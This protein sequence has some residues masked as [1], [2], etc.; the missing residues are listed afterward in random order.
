MIKIGLTGGIGSGKTSVCTVWQK[1]GAYIIN[2]DDLAKEIMVSDSV[3][4]Q[5][6][7]NTFG[8]KTYQPD[9]S[10]NREYL[11]KQAFEKGR[12]NELNGIVHPRIPQKMES[13]VE[14]AEEKGYP[15]LVYEAILLLNGLKNY[16]LD[17]VVIVL[18]DREK[19]LRWTQKRDGV[20]EKTIASRMKKQ[21]DFRKL[22]FMADFVIQNDGS[23]DE[24]EQRAKSLYY[25]LTG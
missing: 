16:Q 9:G 4:K 13:I 24:L 20:S 21:P 7:I 11:A 25:S 2:A 15:A 22:T 17:F 8:K 19:R 23:L 14:K 18:A 3:V 1:C 6:L 5:Q 12:V 10:L